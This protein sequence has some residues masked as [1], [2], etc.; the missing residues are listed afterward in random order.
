MFIDVIRAQ[1]AAA[2]GLELGTFDL[3]A[4]IERQVPVIFW[5]T[6]NGLD[7][8]GYRLWAKDVEH[9]NIPVGIATGTATLYFGQHL[10]QISEFFFVESEGVLASS[11]KIWPIGLFLWL[12]DLE[13]ERYRVEL[14]IKAK[15]VPACK[16]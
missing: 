3:K 15:A 2:R 14:T 8:D 9:S 16:E 11:M 12:G 1:L 10:K 4:A 13:L 5:H 6:T 7:Y